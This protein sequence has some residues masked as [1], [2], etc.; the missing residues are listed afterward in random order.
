MINFYWQNAVLGAI[1]V[2]LIEWQI[3]SS[4]LQTYYLF[5]IHVGFKKMYQMNLVI[6]FNL[7]I[8]IMFYLHFVRFYYD[9]LLAA[10]R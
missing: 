8:L 7:F 10:C 9:V 6:Y 1:L 4:I 2:L 3:Y 5:G